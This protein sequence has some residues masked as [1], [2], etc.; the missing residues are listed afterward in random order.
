MKTNFGIWEVDED[1]G[2]LGE[3]NPT[4]KYKIP[5]E[6]LWDT[7]E[8][9]GQIVWEWFIHLTEK[10]WIK[11]SNFNDF[12]TAFLF[13][14]DFLKINKPNNVRKVSIAQTIYIAQQLIELR[15][16][17]DNGH[18]ELDLGSEEA[19]KKIEEAFEMDSKVKTLIIK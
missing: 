5:K 11:T 1:F 14:Q 16:Q 15:E 10:T 12:V 17:S 4:H 18:S 2:L 6:S 13:A 7:T 9:K 3:V 19:L 8:Y